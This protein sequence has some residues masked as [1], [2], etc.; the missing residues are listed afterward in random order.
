[1]KN[2]LTLDEIQEIRDDLKIDILNKNREEVL[3][4]LYQRNFQNFLKNMEKEFEEMLK[5]VI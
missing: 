5:E 1:M 3:E 2:E 4:L